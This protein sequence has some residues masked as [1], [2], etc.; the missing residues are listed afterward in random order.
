MI[1]LLKNLFKISCNNPSN[2]STNGCLC[3]TS[4]QLNSPA[5]IDFIFRKIPSAFSYLKCFSSTLKLIKWF[6]SQNNMQVIC[7]EINKIFLFKNYC[8]DTNANLGEVLT[9]DFT[10]GFYAR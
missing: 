7:H 9:S 6:V 4:S 5:F 10:F 2:S 8:D 1:Y 3:I